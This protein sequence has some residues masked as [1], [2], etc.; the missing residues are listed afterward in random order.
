MKQSPGKIQ[1]VTG[2]PLLGHSFSVLKDPLAFLVSMKE[3]YG[4]IIKVNI[5]IK[6][7]Y[8]LQSPGAA[9]HV[10]QENSKNYYKPGAAKLMKRFL[11]NGLAT[12]NGKLWLQQRRLMQ[13]AFHRKK[14][15]GLF[16]TICHETGLLV[17]D[18]KSLNGNN[19][20]EVNS[21]FLELTLSNIT[22]TMFGTNIQDDLHIIS[23]LVNR[24]VAAAAGSV[25]SLVKFPLYVPTPANRK[26]LSANREFEKII[27]RIINDR[28]NDEHTS[29]GDLLDML[30]HAH[31]GTND[32]QMSATQLRDE[33]T[34]IFMAGHET[35]AQTLSW[36]FYNLASNPGIKTRLQEES[37][38]W[39][40]QGSSFEGLQQMEF[41][42]SVIEETMRLYPP[43]WLMARKSIN[44]D[45]INGCRLP[46]SSTVLVNIYGMNHSKTYWN[47]P[48]QFNPGRMHKNEQLT[49]NPFLFIPFGA[50]QRPC[51]GNLFAMMVMQV[52]VAKLVKEFDFEI[53][54]GFR[55][56]PEANVTLRAKRGITLIIK[57]TGQHDQQ[58]S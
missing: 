58:N 11:G 21:R 42:R 49:R 41:T 25:T 1:V 48:Q 9:R 34:T 22:R 17:N 56:I 54:Q 45:I 52:V 2:L 44:D 18:W 27:Y 13:P 39:H 29:G 12:S 30:L 51:I 4:E 19:T 5:G 50:G 53:P 55:A 6:N 46:A 38:A 32:Q 15:E 10:L 20:V 23:S 8:L 35:T 14:I 31:K 16:N 40:N 3:Q 36:V 26:F 57:K 43:V 37:K 47:D 28:I 7:Y 33:I 24:L